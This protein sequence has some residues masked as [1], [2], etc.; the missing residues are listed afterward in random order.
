[1]SSTSF[2][3][4]ADSASGSSELGCELSPSV[5]S[6][7]GVALDSPSTGRAYR[8]TATS[9]SSTAPASAQLILFAE[10][11][12]AK[13]S[14]SSAQVKGSKVRDPGCGSKCSGSCASA[15]PIGCSLRIALASEFSELTGFSAGWKRSATPG[16]R[17]WWK[18]DIPELATVERESSLLPT[19]TACNYGSNQGG[20]AGRVGKV[21][22]SLEQMARRGMLPTPTASRRSG[23]QSHG[24]N[25]VLGRMNPRFLEWM[26]TFPIG[27]TRRKRSVMP[28]CQPSPSE[29][30]E[31]SGA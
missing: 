31:Q 10:A 7:H 15:D 30:A 1:M 21:R 22:Y 3:A 9:E 28:S 17:S 20:A 24:R 14:V 27:W 26:M 8:S 18:L 19:P 23:L 12:L 25:A 2:P 29:S 4:L 11:S 13:T 16:G 5:R 6:S